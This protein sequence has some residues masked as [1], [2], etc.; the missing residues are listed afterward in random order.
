MRGRDV[1]PHGTGLSDAELRTGADRFLSEATK[2]LSFRRFAPRG[3]CARMG[4]L[5]CWN[6][7]RCRVV[8]CGPSP[9]G[10]G[11]LR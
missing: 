4:I 5:S 10:R 8:T 1:E 6:G 3:S 9:N 2:I 7:V 11:R